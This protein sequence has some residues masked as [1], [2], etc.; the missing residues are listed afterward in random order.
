MAKTISDAEFEAEV[1]KSDTPVLVDFFANWCGPCKA[2]LPVVEELAGEYEGKVKVVKINVDEAAETP[3]QFGVMSI[4]TFIIF[5]KG[6]PV[7]TF[8]GVKSKEDIKKELDAAL[9]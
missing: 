5:K 6:A 3:A 2:M 1:L 9:E 4:P 8:V 7:S